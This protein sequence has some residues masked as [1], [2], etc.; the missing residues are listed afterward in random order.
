MNTCGDA[1]APC[2]TTCGSIGGE[3]RPELGASPD[4]SCPQPPCDCVPEDAPKALS[5]QLAAC[6]AAVLRLGALDSR[7]GMSAMA[8]LRKAFRHRDRPEVAGSC[9]W[10]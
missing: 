2:T 7:S 8:A 5:P 4:I 6:R 10:C 1:L 9:H 3:P